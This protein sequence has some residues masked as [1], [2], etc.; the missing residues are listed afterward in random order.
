VF[1]YE[2]TGFETQKSLQANYLIK[3]LSK[4]RNTT[5]AAIASEDLL[6]PY[7]E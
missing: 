3:A 6:E 5:S 1:K 2:K 7:T 4:I